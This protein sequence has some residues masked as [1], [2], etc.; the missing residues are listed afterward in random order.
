M[1]TRSFAQRINDAEVM[2]SGMV[3]NMETAASRGWSEEKNEHLMAI[4]NEAIQLNDEQEKLKAELKMKTAELNAKET[5]LE[6]SM[7]EAKGVVKLAF[8]QT[9]WKEF[10]ITDK[11]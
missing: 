5:Q 2:H 9:Q 3:N 7:K 6:E 10:G 1:S 11:R 8:P 4:R